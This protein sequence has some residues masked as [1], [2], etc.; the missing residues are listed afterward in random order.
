MAMALITP[1]QF[2]DAVLNTARTE[3]RAH[4]TTETMHAKCFSFASLSAVRK[5]ANA[6]HDAQLIRDVS[7]H[8]GRRVWAPGVRYMLDRITTLLRELEQARG[9][10][11]AYALELDALK[12]PA[13]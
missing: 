12:R 13:E 2:A 7:H 9:A 1:Q 8:A 5:A 11:A 3:P 10:I 6:A 4:I